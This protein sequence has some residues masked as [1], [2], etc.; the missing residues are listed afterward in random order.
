M[1]I[2]IRRHN[3]IGLLS[4]YD[5]KSFAFRIIGLARSDEAKV[6]AEELEEILAE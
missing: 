6:L 3:K 5:I 2:H 1:P 4:D